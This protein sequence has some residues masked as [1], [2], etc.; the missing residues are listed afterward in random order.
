MWTKQFKAYLVLCVNGQAYVEAKDKELYIVIDDVPTL[1]ADWRP[2]L[3]YGQLRTLLEQL[4][5]NLIKQA[6]TSIPTYKRKPDSDA[7][8]IV[9][10][11]LYDE[12]EHYIVR[13][14]EMVTIDACKVFRENARKTSTYTEHYNTS[15]VLA[16]TELALQASMVETAHQ[17]EAQ[18][19]QQLK[20]IKEKVAKHILRFT[21]ETNSVHVFTETAAEVVVGLDT[22]NPIT[23]PWHLTYLENAFKKYMQGVEHVYRREITELIKTKDATGK[24]QVMYHYLFDH[25]IKSTTSAQRPHMQT[26]AR[27]AVKLPEKQLPE[28]RIAEEGVDLPEWLVDSADLVL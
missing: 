13:D 8:P 3:R 25:H 6:L 27:R 22:F 4:P 21:K 23:T 2:D 17:N 18:R 11:A 15:T 14:I 12:T 7:L 10:D 5:P 16:A 20:A 26:S 24:L 1:W 19:P 28:M 9:I